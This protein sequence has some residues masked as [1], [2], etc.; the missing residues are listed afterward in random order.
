M[1][2]DC[3]TLF[4][5]NLPYDLKEDMIGDRFRPF[6]EIQEIRISRNWSTN[7]SKGFAFIIFKEHISAKAA[8]I[9]MNGKELKGYP[10]RQLKIDFDTKQKAKSSYKTNME[11]DGNS[12]FNKEKKK[13]ER[14]KQH[15]KLNEKNKNSKIIKK[16][17]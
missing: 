8:L 2:E 3:K 11:D 1:P 9:K 16:R 13:E 4:V 15:H 5:K 7:Q 10:D 17:Y 12:R 6:G 14:S